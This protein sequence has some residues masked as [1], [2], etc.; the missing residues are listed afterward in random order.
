[1]S[2]ADK[3]EATPLPWRADKQ[4]VR[5]NQIARSNRT[6]TPLID[7][8]LATWWRWVAAGRAP[9]PKRLSPGTTVWDLSEVLAFLRAEKERS[10]ILNHTVRKNHR[11]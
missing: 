7:I 4:F 5:A 2:E 3:T 8:S 9:Q 10:E 11:S 6:K 1:M